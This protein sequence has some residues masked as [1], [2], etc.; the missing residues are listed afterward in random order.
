MNLSNTTTL[1]DDAQILVEDADPPEG[2]F[3]VDPKDGALSID[4]S[5][6]DGADLTFVTTEPVGDIIE[7][8]KADVIGHGV[9]HHYKENHELNDALRNQLADVRI[10]KEIMSSPEKT[11]LIE[12]N[13]TEKIKGG[14]KRKSTDNFCLACLLF[15]DDLKLPKDNV[16]YSSTYVGL[17]HMKHGPELVQIQLVSIGIDFETQYPKKVKM[18]VSEYPNFEDQVL[19]L[20]Q[21]KKKM[22]VEMKEI[23]STILRLEGSQDANDQG[24]NSILPGS[25]R[26][27]NLM[28]VI[29]RFFFPERPSKIEVW[30]NFILVVKGPLQIN[31]LLSERTIKLKELGLKEQPIVLIMQSDKIEKRFVCIGDVH[32]QVESTIKAIDTAFKSFYGL[33]LEYPKEAS[34]PWIV[35]QNAIY[36]IIRETDIDIPCVKT[37][38]SDLKRY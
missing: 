2:N 32:Y 27:I 9:L 18:L 31:R 10:R 34:Y 13:A 23:Y 12:N 15:R 11:F 29:T 16:G 6:I 4:S 25:I 30:D 35:I 7:T 21:K 36:G 33:Q 28:E 3:E 5:M 8:L 19:Q 14:V 17:R 22:P 24:L 37:L 1:I 20:V 26:G 38:V